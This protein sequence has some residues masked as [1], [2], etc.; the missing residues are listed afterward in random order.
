[1]EKEHDNLNSLKLVLW[2]SGTE[3]IKKEVKIVLPDGVDIQDAKVVSSLNPL[4]NVQV[5]VDPASRNTAVINFD[6]LSMKEGCLI[7]LL[8]T[9]SKEEAQENLLKKG[10]SDLEKDL[11]NHLKNEIS[12]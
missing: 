1:M 3:N 5:N 7:S 6:N 8:H 10:I 12:N 9:N 4:N 11:P 2:N